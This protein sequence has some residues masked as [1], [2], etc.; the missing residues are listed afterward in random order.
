MLKH[1]DGFWMRMAIDLAREGRTPFGAVLVDEEGNHTGAFNTTKLQGATAH[2]EINVIRKISDLD[3]D[4]ARDLI[5]YTT[6][7]PCPMCM[8]AIIWAGI[9]T[10]VFGAS[11]NDAAQHG[12]QIMISSHQV[13]EAG[14]YDIEIRGGIE[15]EDCLALFTV[16]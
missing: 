8:S 15:R 1:D 2:A 9:G 16:R 3:Y 6:V 11:I 13:T 4:D 5:L 14:W 7:E 10:V 12:K